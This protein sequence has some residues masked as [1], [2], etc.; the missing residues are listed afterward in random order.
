VHVVFGF[1]DLKT[2]CK[3]AMVVRKEGKKVRR[4][5]HLGTGNYNPATALVYTDLGLFTADKTMADDVSALFNFLTGYSQKHQW[6]KLVVAPQDLK[7]RTI[8]LIDE[9]AERA[10]QGKK[11]RIFAKLNAI[12]DRRTIEAL[13]RASRA[14]VPIEL[15]V[16]GICCLRPG[17]PGISENIR[18]RSIVDRFLEHSRILVFGEGNKQQVFLSSAD[19][20]PRNFDR[21]VE[22]MYPVE[23]EDLRRRIVE[24][25]IP[26]YLNDNRR[27]RMLTADGSYVRTECR[28]ADA[29]HRSQIEL[30]TFAPPRFPAAAVEAGP[31]R[32]PL[33]EP[34]ESN[35]APDREKKKKDKKGAAA[36]R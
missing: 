18:V 4:Y 15:L 30:L 17:L 8:E 29:A 25:I 3:L 26:A 23:A 36:S 34:L 19:W 28:D 7:R 33:A 16:R 2:H 1:M 22:V 13:Y 9:Q 12:V 6:Q 5:V 27:S 32:I 11:S 35:G 20:M 21:R 24:E 14:G 31:T 10:R